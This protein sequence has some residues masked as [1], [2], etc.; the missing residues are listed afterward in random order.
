MELMLTGATGAVGGELLTLAASAG[1]NVTGTYRGSDARAEGLR[2]A[3]AGATGRLSLHACD[4]TDQDVVRS[5]LARLSVDYCPDALVHLASPKLEV[6]PVSRVDWAACSRQLDVA[7]KALVLLAPPLLKRMSR[8][9]RGHLISVLSSVVLG[10][11]P[12]GFAAYTTAKYA[13][14]G[15]TKSLAAEYAG[16]G[17]SVNMVSPGPMNSELL[18]ALPD[19][20]TEQMRNSIPGGQWIDPRS[21]ARLIF[22][23]I[24]EAGPELT[25]CNMPLTSGMAF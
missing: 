11:P 10:V 21:V 20:L 24:S 4:L 5:L 15:Y 17:I 8:R 1:W 23:L 18:S 9:G 7:L 6:Q 3:W 19:L 22:W 25:G 12:K 14:A 2:E 13:L 16:R